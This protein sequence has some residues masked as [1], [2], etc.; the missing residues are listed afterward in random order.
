MNECVITITLP[1]PEVFSVNSTLELQVD[2]TGE[3]PLGESSRKQEVLPACSYTYKWTHWP[4]KPTPSIIRDAEEQAE[5]QFRARAEEKDVLERARHNA[6]KELARFL[7]FAGY[8]DVIFVEPVQLEEPPGPFE[9]MFEPL[10]QY[11]QGLV[12]AIMPQPEEPANPLED[13]FKPLIQSLQGLGEITTPQPE[14]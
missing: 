7:I 11:L 13:M 9:D 12:K 1:S 8:K 4:A 2:E 3:R 6:E 14:D 10:R 5:I